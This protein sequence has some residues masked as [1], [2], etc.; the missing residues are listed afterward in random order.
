MFSKIP[1]NVQPKNKPIQ[2]EETKPF[3]Y[4]DDIQKNL[5]FLYRYSN[6]AAGVRAF[7]GTDQ[8]AVQF[9]SGYCLRD[10]G[11]VLTVDG[12]CE[13]GIFNLAELMLKFL[14]SGRKQLLG[15]VTGNKYF[16]DE[17]I[18]VFYDLSKIS[19]DEILKVE[20][21]RADFEASH[22]QKFKG[23]KPGARS[24]IKK[25]V[26]DVVKGDL[27]KSAKHL[28][29]VLTD[30][31]SNAQDD[32]DRPLYFDNGELFEATLAAKNYTFKRFQ[33]HL[34]ELN[35]PKN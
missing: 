31:V 15:R 25:Y 22:S 30:A 23:R 13:M 10:F 28:W 11:Q 14:N 6:A 5:D 24:A 21:A 1:I 34:S 20:K 9:L 4:L 17:V 32:K 7:G 3:I 18:S 33:N 29:K 12:I 26:E 27:D 16:C 19:S 8:D 35:N 2:Q